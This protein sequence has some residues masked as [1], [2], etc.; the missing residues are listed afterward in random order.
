MKPYKT[1][2]HYINLGVQLKSIRDLN[3]G[4]KRAPFK[5]NLIFDEF[6]IILLGDKE[7]SVT[8]N[9]NATIVDL[10]MFYLNILVALHNKTTVL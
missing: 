9:K 4:S 2:E 1:N 7:A 8:L 5:A 10:K 6:N 3:L